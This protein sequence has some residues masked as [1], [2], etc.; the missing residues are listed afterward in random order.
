MIGP[1]SKVAS[2]CTVVAASVYKSLGIVVADGLDRRG[3]TVTWEVPPI[4]FFT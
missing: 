2:S 3:G 1:E 4:Q